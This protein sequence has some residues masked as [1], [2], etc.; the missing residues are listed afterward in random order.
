MVFNDGEPLIE[1][2][3]HQ[4]LSLQQK[5]IST[6][7]GDDVLY[8]FQSVFKT[9]LPSELGAVSYEIHVIH[10]HDK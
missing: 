10:K 2:V 8:T 5:S 7:A 6:F 3:Q 9:S 1:P 4:I